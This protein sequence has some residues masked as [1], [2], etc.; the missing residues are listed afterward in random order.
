MK[1]SIFIISLVLAMAFAVGTANVY[2]QSGGNGYGMGSGM[3]GGH[4]AYGMRSGMMGGR[5]DVPAKLPAPENT[6]WVAKLNEILKL[7]IQS[8]AQYQA[9]Q[10][11]FN[12]YMPYMMVIPQEESH[13]ASIEQLFK[14]YDLP[15]DV[16]TGTVA[17]NKTL[18]ETY[19]LSV[20]LEGDLLPRYEWLVKKAEDRDT[21]QVLN[22]ILLQSRWH[23]V[24]FEHALRMGHGYGYSRGYGMM[25]GSGYGSYSMGPGMM[26]D[27]GHGM[28]SGMMRGDGSGYGM[29]RGYGQQSRS[30]GKPIDAKEAEAMM[31]DYLKSSRNPNLKLGKITDAGGAFEAEILTKKD[32]LV[33]RI[34]IDKTMGH[35]RSVY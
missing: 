30:T 7:E 22:A 3:M 8:L 33:D 24:M 21:A 28:S 1:K 29:G 11:K 31:K 34:L 18:T 32:D 25:G 35:I 2:S 5:I 10:E 6:E 16:K 12:A 20:K 14:A 4:G 27:S 26:G 15:A 13:I 9:D 17:E 23:L 19:E